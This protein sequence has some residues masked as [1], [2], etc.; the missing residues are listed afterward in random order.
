MGL[1]PN[2]PFLFGIFHQINHPATGVP[3]FR[4]SEGAVL[5]LVRPFLT[6]PHHGAAEGGGQMPRYTT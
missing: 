4:P 3:P 5:L 1:T 2:H 6:Q